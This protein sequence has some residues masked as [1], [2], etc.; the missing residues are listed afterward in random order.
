MV[1]SIQLVK[2]TTKAAEIILSAISWLVFLFLDFLDV[3][4][5]IFFR[6]VDGLLER[7]ASS[8]CYCMEFEEKKTGVLEDAQV[9]DRESELSETLHGRKNSIRELMGSLGISLVPKIWR[10]GRGLLARNGTRWSDCG[11]NSCVEW[12]ENA[13][14]PKLHVVVKEPQRGKFHYP[15]TLPSWVIRFCAQ[16]GKFIWINII[17]FGIS[18]PNDIRENHILNLNILYLLIFRHSCIF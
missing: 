2:W 9:V 17:K 7:K 14:D 11:C 10:N 12:M 5:C 3:F 18:Q 15:T 16:Q 4:M 1:S 6:L 13:N 8:S